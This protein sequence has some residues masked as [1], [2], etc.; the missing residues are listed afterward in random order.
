MARSSRAMMS[1]GLSN[2][3]AS[4]NVCGSFT[5]FAAIRRACYA[6]IRFILA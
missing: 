3:F 4:N 2:C 1:P 5:M 6:S